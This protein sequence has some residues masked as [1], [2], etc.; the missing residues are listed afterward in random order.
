MNFK[1]KIFKKKIVKKNHEIN[2]LNETLKHVQKQRYEEKKKK[3]NLIQSSLFN[4]DELRQQVKKRGNIK[5]KKNNPNS[6]ALLQLQHLT[7]KYQF[8]EA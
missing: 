1:K 3:M 5:S 2:S 6:D 8:I 4:M 7:S